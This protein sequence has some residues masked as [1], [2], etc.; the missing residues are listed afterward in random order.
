[1]RKTS[2]WNKFFKTN[3]KFWVSGIAIIATFILAVIGKSVHMQYIVSIHK[4]ILK[5]LRKNLFPYYCSRLKHN[6]MN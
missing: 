4:V 6:N 5:S 1:M 2:F 3:E